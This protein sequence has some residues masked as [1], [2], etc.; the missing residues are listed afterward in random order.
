M[1]L[2]KNS[3]I[4]VAETKFKIGDK[5]RVVKVRDNGID[6]VDNS[7]KEL[8]RR[9]IGDVYVVNT[10]NPNRPFFKCKLD[11]HYGVK[12]YPGCNYVWFEDELELVEE[13]EKP[14]TKADLRDGMVVE[15][16][17]GNRRLVVGDAFIG[18][19]S[20]TLI[21][22]FTDDLKCH[23]GF[24]MMEIVKVYTS[25]HKGFD[26]IFKDLYL[27]LIWERKDEAKEMTVA[28]IEK[29][30]GYKVKIVD[31]EVNS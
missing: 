4:K 6:I 31:K 1:K 9:L 29:Q 17:D 14:F 23:N 26:K 19:N 24:P 27:T 18:R 12:D 20:Y 25:S 8:K 3:D 30:L 2:N 5:V 21:A 13:K 7:V 22:E 16:K 28:E 10:I 15:Y 11:T